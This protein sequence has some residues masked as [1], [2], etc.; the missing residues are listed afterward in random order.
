MVVR[1]C[2]LDDAVTRLGICCRRAPTAR[3]R[4]LNQT[5]RRRATPSFGGEVQ[6]PVG[7]RRHEPS[8]VFDVIVG[9]GT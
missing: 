7:L 4:A 3:L 5:T 2:G 6:E 9:W 8:P 1:F